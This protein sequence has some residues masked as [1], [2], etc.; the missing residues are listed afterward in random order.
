MDAAV[1]GLQ[2][3]LGASD[4]R[5]RPREARGDSLN[6]AGHEHFRN[7]TVPLIHVV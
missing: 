3:R 2:R 7:Y 1:C 5:F 6:K 4:R